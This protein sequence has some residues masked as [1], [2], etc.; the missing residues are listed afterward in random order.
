M[1]R[2]INTKEKIIQ[3]ACRLFETKGYHASGLNEILKESEAP[4]GSLYYHFPKGKEELAVEA[5]MLAGA[6]IQKKIFEILETSEN[7]VDALSKNIENIASIIDL[8]QRPSD[9]SISLIALETYSESEAIRIT[10]EG[11]FQNLENIYAAHLI[12]YGIEEKKAHETGQVIS[13]MV[14]GGITLSLIKKNGDPLRLVAKQIPLL[15]N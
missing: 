6:N 7:P 12:R 5:V 2:K 8:E 10:C 1:E 9:I 14:E 13:M 11:I 4:K 15:L 3:S